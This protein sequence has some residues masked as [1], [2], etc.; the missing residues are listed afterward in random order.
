MLIERNA[1][2]LDAD[3]RTSRVHP[4]VRTGS[5]S[6][7]LAIFAAVVAL[8]LPSPASPAT[9]TAN[10]VRLN[11]LSPSLHP[12]DAEL[13][14]LATQSFVG[15]ARLGP[16]NDQEW[17]DS[18]LNVD[19]DQKKLGCKIV[20]YRIQYSSGSWSE[21]YAPGV[22]DLYKKPGETLRRSWATFNDH[23]FEIIYQSAT[24]PIQFDEAAPNARETRS[25]NTFNWSE[26]I[27]SGKAFNV[28]LD[29][30]PRRPDAL[31]T[32]KG[33]ET[34]LVEWR[35]GTFHCTGFNQGTQ[36]VG[37]WAYSNADLSKNEI[38]LWGALFTFDR[39]GN[40]YHS[41]Y[42]LVGH[43]TLDARR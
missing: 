27:R 18:S 9:I 35:D 1:E 31:G 11:A 20:A 43:L 38:S 33:G 30:A 34:Y 40:V 16:R 14:E 42:G 24:G 13:P 7:L 19:L 10:G 23:S 2:M 15:T 28:V 29:R 8:S 5:P 17:V 32:L 37:E 6:G 39:D 4:E 36:R 22:N 12:Q 3:D 21:W 41:R 26:H 25:S